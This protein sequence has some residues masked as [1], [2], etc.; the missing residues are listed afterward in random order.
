[1]N[2]PIFE[3]VCHSLKA[4]CE[5]A[6]KVASILLALS[7]KKVLGELKLSCV[8]IVYFLVLISLTIIVPF[9]VRMRVMSAAFIIRV[10]EYSKF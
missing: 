5:P 7:I 4:S 6:L 9:P 8:L 3:V 10:H 2:P 1:M